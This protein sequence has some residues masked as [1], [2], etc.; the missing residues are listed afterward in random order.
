MDALL[1]ELNDICSLLM[2]V[3]ADSRFCF[4]KAVAMSLLSFAV[5]PPSPNSFVQP[6]HTNLSLSSTSFARILS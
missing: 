2:I 4:N 5:L 1:L 6:S 3:V